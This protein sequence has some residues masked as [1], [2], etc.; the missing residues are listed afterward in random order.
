MF[1]VD[2]PIPIIL[3]CEASVAASIVGCPVVPAEA[4]I[5]VGHAVPLVVL[6][7]VVL[8]LSGDGTSVCTGIGLAE[9]LPCLLPCPTEAVAKGHAV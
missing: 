3:H 6:L 5:G 8:L 1:W 7:P 4:H 9:I 2:V